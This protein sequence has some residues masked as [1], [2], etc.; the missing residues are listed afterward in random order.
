MALWYAAQTFVS[1]QTKVAEKKLNL[2]ALPETKFLMPRTKISYHSDEDAASV[3]SSEDSV[4]V[5]V[6]RYALLFLLS[7]PALYCCPR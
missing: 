6:T 1:E 2:E 4:E 3:K 5:E 7:H